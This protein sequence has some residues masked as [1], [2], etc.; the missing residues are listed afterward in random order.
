MTDLK[1]KK[2]KGVTKARANISRVCGRRR[3]R[4]SRQGA[5]ERR[6]ATSPEWSSSEKQQTNDLVG[7]CR[8]NEIVAGA[9]K[10]IREQRRREGKKEAD[11]ETGRH[12]D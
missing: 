8:T 11:K 12:T 6:L 3:R 5:R 7:S 10:A 9:G 2:W 4:G 1:R